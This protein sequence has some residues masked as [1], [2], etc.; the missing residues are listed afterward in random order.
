MMASAVLSVLS[1]VVTFSYDTAP[2][3]V[4]RVLTGGAGA[5]LVY[6]SFVLSRGRR[7]GKGADAMLK[8]VSS[9]LAVVAVYSLP[10]ND[11]SIE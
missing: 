2:S 4:T 11:D 3:W 7:T 6:N 5:L 1:L 8:L 10:P 9:G